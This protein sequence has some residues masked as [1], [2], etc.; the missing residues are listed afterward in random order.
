MKTTTKHCTHKGTHII[1]VQKMK[2][3]LPK[4]FQVTCSFKV[5]AVIIDF[6]KR[7]KIT[8]KM[9]FLDLSKVEKEL[10]YQKDVPP[11]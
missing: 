4:T 8:Q 6:P 2:N 9:I 5:Q 1:T 7:Y 3:I 11:L 10:K